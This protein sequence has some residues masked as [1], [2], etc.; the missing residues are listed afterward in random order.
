MMTMRIHI[1]LRDRG[2]VVQ[3]QAT[4]LRTCHSLVF[5]S[6]LAYSFFA[7]SHCCVL[8]VEFIRCFSTSALDRFRSSSAFLYA[9]RAR[10]DA[11]NAFSYFSFVLASRIRED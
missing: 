8:M 4:Y 5:C 7:S 10:S 2:L 1:I 11:P 3:V 6:W 9:S